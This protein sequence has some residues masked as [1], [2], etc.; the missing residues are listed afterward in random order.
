MARHMNFSARSLSSRPGQFSETVSVPSNRMTGDRSIKSLTPAGFERTH[1]PTAVQPHAIVPSLRA[2]GC[3][4]V[5]DNI[6]I[7][8]A[9]GGAG[10]TP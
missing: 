5:A 8:N 1:A 6:L 10:S 4:E 7:L 3:L 9:L 2:R